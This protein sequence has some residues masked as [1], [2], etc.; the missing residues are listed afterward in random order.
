LIDL[1]LQ[2]AAAPAT[3][4]AK[5]PPPL[6]ANLLGQIQLKLISNDKGTLKFEVHNGTGWVCGVFPSVCTDG[7]RTG[8]HA[9]SCH[10][11]YWTE[12]NERNNRQTLRIIGFTAEVGDFL[13]EIATNYSQGLV[14]DPTYLNTSIVQAIGMSP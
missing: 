14:S 5:T 3:A 10:Q 9:Q 1:L 6:P 7:R 12:A 2:V 4:A 13:N 11:Q 8:G